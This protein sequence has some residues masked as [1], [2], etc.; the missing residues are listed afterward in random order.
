M[1]ENKSIKL[2]IELEH[3]TTIKLYEELV[4][5]FIRQEKELKSAIVSS[6][7]FLTSIFECGLL[8]MCRLLK[9]ETEKRDE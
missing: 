5:P 6:N 2:M 1:Q 8:E 9:K 3:P 7:E 4:M